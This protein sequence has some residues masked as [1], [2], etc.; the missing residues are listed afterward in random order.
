MYTRGYSEAHRGIK[1]IQIKT[2]KREAKTSDMTFL[3]H[4]KEKSLFQS[5]KI[6]RYA[7][8]IKELASF[9]S[10]STQTFLLLLL[11]TVVCNLKPG[12]VSVAGAA[13]AHARLTDLHPQQVCAR[14]M[15]W[16]SSN[17]QQT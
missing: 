9:L 13:R 15:I 3:I 5:Y 6:Y 12:S 1:Q 7:N 2:K 10:C 14:R 16:S 11:V 17:L 4:L 8:S